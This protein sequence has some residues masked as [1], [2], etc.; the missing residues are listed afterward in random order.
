MSRRV[1]G[2]RVP[3]ALL[4]GAT[5]A[6]LAPATGQYTVTALKFTVR[7]GDR[8]CTIDADLY[9]PT[10]AGRAPALLA[11]KVA[12]SDDAYV[13]NRGIKPVTVVSSPGNTGVLEL[14]VAGG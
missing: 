9:R 2:Y 13:G 12:A 4:L 1:L 7:A 8:T 5:L 10:G 14:P 3:L 11:T 6:A